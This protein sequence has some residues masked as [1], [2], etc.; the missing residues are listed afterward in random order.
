MKKFIYIFIIVIFLL[1]AYS[2]FASECPV[3]PDGQH[4]FIYHKD[5]THIINKGHRY[6]RVCEECGLEEFIGYKSKYD[7]CQCVGHSFSNW[8]NPSIQ[9]YDQGHKIT[10][11]C[12]RCGFEQVNYVY[13]EGCCECTG[14]HDYLTQISNTHTSQGHLKYDE[15]SLC[16][17]IIF[18]G[19]VS[20]DDCCLCG[21]HTYTN[22]STPSI[23]HYTQGHKQTRTCTKCGSIQTR[24]VYDYSCCQCTNNHTYEYHVSNVH[25]S[26][27]HETYNQCIYCGEKVHIGY[28]TINDCCCGF[29]TYGEYGPISSEHTAQ[30][31]LQSRVCTKC[32][33]VDS[34]YVKSDDCC[35]CSGHI[36][37]DWSI[38][39]V[40]TEQGHLQTRMCTRCGFK[41]SKYINDFNCS[42]CR[43]EPASN[44]EFLI[45]LQSKGIPPYSNGNLYKANFNT[46]KEYGLI[47][48]GMPT[49]VVNNEYAEGEYRYLGYTYLNDVFTN[50]YFPDDAN[51]GI[52]PELWNF[53]E[54]IGAIKSYDQLEQ[55]VQKPY[56]LNTLL[57]G[58]GAST[59]T[60]NDIGT[61]KAK[62]QTGATW[63]NTGS[64]YTKKD[65]GYY[66][67]FMVPAMGF[68]KIQGQLIPS[69]SEIH[70]NA[71]TQTYDLALTLSA[72]IDKPN[73]EIKYLTI[74]LY[75]GSTKTIAHSNN[76]TVEKHVE[77]DKLNS[78]YIELEYTGE[79]ELES[80]FGDKYKKTV[81]CTVK[82]YND[83]GDIIIIDPDPDPDPEPNNEI[84]IQ[85]IDVIGSFNHWTNISNIFG[86]SLPYNR[87]RFLSLE[88]IFI[89][90]KANKN[91]DKVV[92]RLSNELETMTYENQLGHFYDY[93][94]DFGLAYVYFPQDSTFYFENTTDLDFTFEYVL[95]MCEETIDFNNRRLKEPYHIIISLMN[96]EETI[97]YKINDIEI[98]GNI[99][100]LIYP[101]PG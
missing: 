56:M 85:D 58:H 16:G 80:I 97:Y 42:L 51:S 54:V 9:H 79:I 38:P 72:S 93:N 27:G 48:Y 84:N 77:I 14:H 65:N 99:Y 66:A 47:V 6:Y 3:A 20:K 5:A 91:V 24:Y 32:G 33:H 64:I 31:H 67:T 68:G 2:V 26:L 35:L 61:S 81:Y 13:D 75:D 41:E 50:M 92:I 4:V 7:C 19:Y 11:T 57:I 55:T 71:Q 98:T 21:N 90:I 25:T 86:E 37:G 34:R 70:F 88:T 28:T 87:H 82:V 22:W 69:V 73:K 12:T 29:H 15:C 89:K 10:R 62:V 76:L 8:S 53:V 101:Q 83:G 96:E 40:H 39:G 23:F 100:D 36:M 30:G 63:L 44:D 95:P 78:E 60:A 46:Y 17:D 52:A 94:V 43:S 18:R 49:Q 45:W 59:L 74:T 1:Q